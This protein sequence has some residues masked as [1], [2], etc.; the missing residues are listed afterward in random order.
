LKN[1]DTVRRV[2]EMRGEAVAHLGDMK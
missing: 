1:R 2:E